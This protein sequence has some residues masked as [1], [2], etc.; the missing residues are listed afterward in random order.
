ML[1]INNTIINSSSVV[2]VYDTVLSTAAAEWLHQEC[3]IWKSTTI[4]D[5][6]PHTMFFEYPLRDPSQHTHRQ[7]VLQHIITEQQQQQDDPKT[8]PRR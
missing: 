2:Q 6:I 1:T 8:A 7:P 4:A 5:N 3:A